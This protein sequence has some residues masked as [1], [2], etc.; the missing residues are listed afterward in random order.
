M[1]HPQATV[2]H[3][4]PF[5][6]ELLEQLVHRSTNAQRLVQRGHIILAA[7]SGSSNSNIARHLHVGYETVRRWRD[8]WHTAQARLEVVEATAKPK[9][10]RQAIEVLLTDEQ[11]P[12]T[13]ATFTFEQFMH[14]MALACETP[15]E[16]ERPVSNWTPRELADE[17]VKRGIVTHIS[18][19]TVGRFLK[20]ERFTAP[21]QALLADAAARRSDG[22]GRA[23]LRRV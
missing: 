2:L 15:G 3:V 11:R 9:L 23:D 20:G 4:S 6:H 13:P 18:P 8:R 16:S 7:A 19:R 1:P 12:G 10:L 22:V 21:S 17:A 5:Q 14:I